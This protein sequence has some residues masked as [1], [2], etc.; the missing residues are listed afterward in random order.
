MGIKGTWRL[1][2]PVWQALKAPAAEAAAA[3]ADAVAAYDAAR[4]AASVQSPLLATAV[5]LTA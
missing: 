2:P 3:N 1:T 5:L 4:E